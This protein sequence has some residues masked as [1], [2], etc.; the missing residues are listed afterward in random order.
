MH[1]LCLC[2]L[3]CPCQ[4]IPYRKNRLFVFVTFAVVLTLVVLVLVGAGYNSDSH[5]SGLTSALGMSYWMHLVVVLL[6]IATFIVLFVRGRREM[7]TERV[8]LPSME[9]A[10]PISHGCN[11]RMK[12]P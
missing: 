11:V 4:S 6:G 5:W 8:R 10:R 3:A 9:R 2:L 7:K 1:H 12:Q